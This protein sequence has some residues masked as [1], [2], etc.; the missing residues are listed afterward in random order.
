MKT[1]FIRKFNTALTASKIFIYSTILFKIAQWFAIE[2]SSSD[3][4]VDKLPFSF[5]FD[6]SVK[7]VGTSLIVSLITI[8]T[9]MLILIF[10]LIDREWNSA[11]KNLYLSVVK[12][13]EMRKYLYQRVNKDDEHTVEK[14]LFNKV[15]KNIVVNITNDKY[16]LFMKYPRTE[17]AD[18]FFIQKMDSM[19]RKIKRENRNFA[20][21]S[22]EYDDEDGVWIIGSRK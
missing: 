16:I 17:Q 14:K 20:I 21:F 19:K 5:I 11:F 8:I 1:H 13:I 9:I 12:T 18:H 22:E 7:I 6:V 3:E 4:L 15:L 2:I 10:E